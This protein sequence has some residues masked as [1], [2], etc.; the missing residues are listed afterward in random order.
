M[1]YGLKFI[2]GGS[3][4]HWVWGGGAIYGGLIGT[5]HSERACRYDTREEAEETLKFIK[6][7]LCKVEL[8]S[9]A[10]VEG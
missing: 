7:G 6:K 5:P 10:L 2:E 3:A 4:G 9:G 1:K 8:V